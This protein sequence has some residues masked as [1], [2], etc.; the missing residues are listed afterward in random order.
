LLRTL[1]GLLEPTRGTVEKVC[2]PGENQDN[3]R[4]VF[5]E[6]SLFP[7][8]TV[9]ENAA[10][11]LKISGVRRRER[12][13]RAHELLARFGFNGF[14]RAY[15]HQLSL[16]MK[17][18]VA[19][20]RGFLSNP[21]ILLMDEPFAAIDCQLKRRLHA[22]LLD[23]W[24]QDRKGVIYVTHDVEEAI[25]LSDRILVMS[26][27]PGGI[28]ADLQVPFPRPRNPQLAVDPEFAPEFTRINNRIWT[29][30]GDQT[31]GET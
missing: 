8:M 17:Q 22:E 10:F 9:L 23:L 18:R 7:W 11:G 28:I 31:I 13:G 2:L 29:L 25:L 12:E 20:I 14:E 6:N 24:E 3:V 19:V 1:A 4:L 27:H 5:Q 15:P 30:L 26:A 21:P 16:G